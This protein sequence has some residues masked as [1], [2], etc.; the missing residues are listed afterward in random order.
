L[1]QS[2]FTNF[3]QKI[4]DVNVIGEQ[5][6]ESSVHPRIGG[7]GLWL[8]RLWSASN[9]NRWID[10]RLKQDQRKQTTSRL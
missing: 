3:F 2:F 5:A 4:L 6:L 9:A 7:Y 10:E 8:I 1:G